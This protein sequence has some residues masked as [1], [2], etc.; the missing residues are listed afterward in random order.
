MQ[1]AKVAILLKEYGDSYETRY[2]FLTEPVEK[3]QVVK[4]LP[5][6]LFD[7]FNALLLLGRL[8]TLHQLGKDCWIFSDGVAWSGRR[9]F[10]FTNHRTQLSQKD[11]LQNLLTE[12]P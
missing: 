4:I 5:K 10:K 12:H 7:R 2:L 9:L 3:G 8:P 1:G 11:V 6:S